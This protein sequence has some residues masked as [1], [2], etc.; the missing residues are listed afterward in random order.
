MSYKELKKT[1]EETVYKISMLAT[2]LLLVSINEL[3]SGYDVIFAE[4][5]MTV[6]IYIAIKT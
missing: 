4:N 2:C 3:L 1:V 5:H 6:I